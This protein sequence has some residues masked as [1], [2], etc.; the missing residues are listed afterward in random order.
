[1]ARMFTHAIPGIKD[2]YEKMRL[3]D[4]ENIRRVV[5]DLPANGLPVIYVEHW[6]STSA[7]AI[8]ETLAGVQMSIVDLGEKV[9]DG[10]GNGARLDDAQR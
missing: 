2:A 6:G 7:V 4:P 9:E 3:G 8:L 5:V 10:Q 1:M